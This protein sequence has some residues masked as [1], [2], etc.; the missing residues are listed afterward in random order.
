[1]IANI[2]AEGISNDAR[3][4][5]RWNRLKAH[6]LWGAL[7]PETL[8]YIK[9][10]QTIWDGLNSVSATAE[11]CCDSKNTPAEGISND[12]HESQRWNRLKAKLLWG[13]LIPERLS[14]I[15]S[16]QN[17]WDGCVHTSGGHL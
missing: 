13:A 15:K 14:Y 8:S 3:E 10:K 17:I 11:V 6:I 2:L 7:I 16:I 1:M 4:F 5:G 9:S 12:G